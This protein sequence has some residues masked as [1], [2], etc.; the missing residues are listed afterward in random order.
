MST[1][2]RAASARTLR[3]TIRGT[4]SGLAIDAACNAY[5]APLGFL[6]AGAREFAGRIPL[7]LK[8][9][10]HDVLED[11]ADPEQALT[12]S[13][14]DAL[15]LGCSAIGFTIYPGSTRRFGM[16]KQIRDMAEEAKRYGLAVVI[17]SYPR[18]SGLSKVGETAIDVVGY[19][20]HIA[21]QLGAHI[22]KVKLPTEHIEQDV[23]RRVYSSKRSRSIPRQ[24][25]CS[26]WCS[27]HSTAV[28]SLSSPV[29]RSNRMRRCWTRFAPFAT[30]AA[31]ALSS[32][33]TR[34]S[35][36]ARRR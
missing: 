1:A 30:A 4:I 13:V 21:C 10:D 18:G 23:A 14:G 15:R 24:S 36:R 17:W 32:G 12:G 19:A 2:P 22:V 31:S 16:Y 27:A 8:V 9:N 7:I 11:A 34:S 28:G 33:G 5:A 3:P 25:A 29:A 6:E 26:T 20:A 35:G